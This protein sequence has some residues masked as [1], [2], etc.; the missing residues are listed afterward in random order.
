MVP[1]A[2]DA[3]FAA[4]ISIACKDRCC[5]RVERLEIALDEYQ[6]ESRR[7]GGIVFRSASRTQEVDDFSFSF[8]ALWSNLI[9]KVPI[10]VGALR[11]WQASRGRFLGL[12]SSG[13]TQLIGTGSGVRICER[14][15]VFN[16]R[17]LVPEWGFEV[18]SFTSLNAP[19][20]LTACAVAIP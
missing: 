20:R 11:K 15:I 1:G 18:C 3:L 6:Q 8:I 2:H 10:G 14:I 4:I 17:D 13:S 9:P 19:L 12:T 5:A 16:K 7:W